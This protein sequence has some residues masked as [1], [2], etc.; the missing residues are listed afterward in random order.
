VL[1]TTYHFCSSRKFGE[2]LH[3]LLAP[4]AAAAAAEEDHITHITRHLRIMEETLLSS[5]G[6]KAVG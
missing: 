2:V 6:I 5:L 1:G 3:S 4:A